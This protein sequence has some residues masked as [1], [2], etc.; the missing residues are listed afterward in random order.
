MDAAPVERGS[1]VHCQT[2]VDCLVHDAEKR[3]RVSW[4]NIGAGLHSIHEPS[5]ST[6]DFPLFAVAGTMPITVWILRISSSVIILHLLSMKKFHVAP[7]KMAVFPDI[8]DA[9]R[10]GLEMLEVASHGARRSSNSNHFESH[11]VSNQPTRTGRNIHVLQGLC[12]KTGAILP[13]RSEGIERGAAVF[14][15]PLWYYSF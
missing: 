5:L 7:H 2:G 4:K 1:K 8:C 3:Q 10:R 11:L 15:A 6:I 9:G 12:T 13:D 14:P